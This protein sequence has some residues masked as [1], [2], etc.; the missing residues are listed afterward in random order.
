[1]RYLAFDVGMRRTGAAFLDENIGI[2]LPLETI[3][4]HSVEELLE[5]ALPLIA[6]RKTDKVILGLPLLPSGE[7][8][9]Q[10]AFVRSVGNQLEAQGI[11]V[12]YR[13]ERYSTPR[14]HSDK[15]ARHSPPPSAYDGDA[16]A[17]CSLLSGFGAGHSA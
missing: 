9:S 7:E 16:A 4:H 11:A 3:R 6:A 10:S 8:G 13:D 1:V 12:E 14:R 2:P 5:A 17:A 15:A